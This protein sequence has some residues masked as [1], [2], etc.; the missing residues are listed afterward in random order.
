MTV[1]VSFAIQE[2]DKYLK[3]KEFFKQIDKT[4]Q[5][6]IELNEYISSHKQL[7]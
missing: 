2:A 3:I 6:K 4:S 7:L 5:S 1:P